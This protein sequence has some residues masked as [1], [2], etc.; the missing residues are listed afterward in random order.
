M[1]PAAGISSNTPYKTASVGGKSNEIRLILQ[2][3][4][5]TPPS[6]N[7]ALRQSID[8]T[9]EQSLDELMLEKEPVPAW[10]SL[11]GLSSTPQE[12]VLNRGVTSSLIFEAEEVPFEEGV[13]SYSRMARRN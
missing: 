2:S 5:V 10:P 7:R 11:A 12:G 8:A 13:K 6:H 1:K 4:A 3:H 9:S